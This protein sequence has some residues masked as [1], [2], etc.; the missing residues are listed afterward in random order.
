MVL[1]YEVSSDVPWCRGRGDPVGKGAR[2]RS[3]CEKK[4]DESKI[5]ER[6]LQARG[7]GR[8]NGE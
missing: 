2:E 1:A 3:R 7:W 5:D 6:S 8:V 4:E